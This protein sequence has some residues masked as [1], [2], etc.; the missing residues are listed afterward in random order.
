MKYIA[1]NVPLWS[2][3]TWD[4]SYIGVDK[5]WQPKTI[6]YKYLLS[7]EL[8]QINI[9]GDVCLLYTGKNT[10]YTT[11]RLAGDALCE[12]EIVSIPWGGTPSVK[13]YCGKFVTGDN[14]IAT[15]NKPDTLLNKYLYYFMKGN[16]KEIASYYRG[17]G[18]K[19]PS[20][21]DVL[22]MRISYP[23]VITQ[24]RIIS[25]FEHIET[26]I[27]LLDR[28]MKSLDELIKARFVEMFG[29]PI[30]NEKNWDQKPLSVLTSKIGS[31]A[32]PKGGK[33]SYISEGISLI[34]SMNVHN[35]YFELKD[36]AH[37]T[38]SQ[39]SQ[40]DNVT[41]KQ[42]DVLLNITGA[43]V[44]RCCTVPDAILPARVNQH[45]CIIR[46][47]DSIIPI[48]LSNMLIEDNYQEHL[49]NIAGSG[50]TREAI[51]KQ[52]IENLS[53]I[54]PPIVLQKQFIDFVK[55][56]DKSKVVVQQALKETRLLFDKMVQEYF[57]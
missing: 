28:Q 1:E 25:R 33:E 3:T 36:L 4:K 49:W 17:A 47:N 31:G 27:D 2:V 29:N 8:D 18:L 41:V 46:C 53:V 10:G 54:V 55:Q 35:G 23:D 57:G 51:T 45:V 20:M 34:R 12:G 30:T 52:Q 14:R 13:Y 21:K 38:D 37:I 9:G 50:A 19:H 44:A 48:F 43:S 15:S 40:L 39:A 24:K 32:T 7:D 16:L 26:I 22:K 56:V 11:E 6:K 5:E 42:N